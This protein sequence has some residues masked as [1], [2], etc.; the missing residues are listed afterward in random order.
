MMSQPDVVMWLG[1]ATLITGALILAAVYRRTL[2]PL[3]SAYWES[4]T[5]VET[6]V[7]TF[8]R[9]YDELARMDLTLIAGIEATKRQLQEGVNEI[10]GI[11]TRLEEISNEVETLSKSSNLSE[12]N[13]ASLQSEFEQ[14]KHNRSIQRPSETLLLQAK[15]TAQSSSSERQMNDQEGLTDTEQ[16]ILL[17][18]RNEGP[19]TSR[20]I[21]TEIAKTR[22]HTARLMK[23]LW[24]Q[25]YVERETHRTPFTYR[26]SN[27]FQQ[28][29]TSKA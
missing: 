23:K 6:I 12:A 13:I 5:I 10:S 14:I 15:T 22:E 18:L 19:K 9:R 27:G 17:F 1:A 8:K 4:K 24:Q 7:T 2:R 3:V 21:E 29:E 20:Q 26:L 11:N 28:L 16:T 25:G